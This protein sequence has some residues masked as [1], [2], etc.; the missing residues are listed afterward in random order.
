MSNH[1]IT[2]IILKT[3]IS[4]VI[5]FVRTP[6][7]ISTIIFII[8][9]PMMLYGDTYS[10]Q[11]LSFFPGLKNMEIITEVDILKSVGIIAGT[12]SYVV[13]I[14][15]RVLSINIIRD[16]SHKL[17]AIIYSLGYGFILSIFS[18]KTSTPFIFALI[19]FGSFWVITMV[20][21]ALLK[22]LNI[23]DQYIDT[24]FIP[25]SE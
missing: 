11:F 4:I 25:K 6:I 22:V 1:H 2:K 12:M 24:I 3:I 19:I 17:L 5:G 20:S 16:N 14:V 8:I 13:M 21:L 10:Y 23:A 9:I 7:F 18:L 15:E